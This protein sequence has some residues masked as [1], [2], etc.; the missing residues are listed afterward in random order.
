MMKLFVPGWALLLGTGCCL[1]QLPESSA[2]TNRDAQGFLIPPT[3][4]VAPSATPV[5]AAAPSSTAAPT[6]SAVVAPL[7]PAAST[8]DGSVRGFVIDDKH[9]LVPGDKLSFQIVEDREPQPKSLIVTDSGEVDV[10]YLGRISVTGKTC[11]QL[12]EELKKQL[13]IDYYYCATV[14]IGLDQVSRTLGRIYVWGQVRNQGAIEIPAGENFTAGK[15]ILRAGGFGDF[16]NKKKI[17]LVRSNADGSKQTQEL[18]M[19]AIL[20][21]GKTEQDVTLQPDDFII[22]PARLVNW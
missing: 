13:E 17:K 22:V 7:P 6:A 15:A 16:A 4:A 14:V 18:N 19:V 21:D 12:G 1:G 2:S 3:T 5:P 10:P 20:E 11:R 8:N 9:K